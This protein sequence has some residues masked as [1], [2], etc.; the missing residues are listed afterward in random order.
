MDVK[1]PK[2]NVGSQ[3]GFGEHKQADNAML[4]PVGLARECG[5]KIWHLPLLVCKA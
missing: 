2:D 5:N 1:I 4:Q 3:E